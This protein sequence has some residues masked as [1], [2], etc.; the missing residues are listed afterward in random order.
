MQ[1]VPVDEPPQPQAQ[2]VFGKH[3]SYIDCE[4]QQ[5]ACE[6][7]EMN[8]STDEDLINQVRIWCYSGVT[9]VLQWCCSGVAVVLQCCY[10]CTAMVLQL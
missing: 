8:K 3:R 1:F 5:R 9:V 7:F 4:L 2:E 10:S 6:Y